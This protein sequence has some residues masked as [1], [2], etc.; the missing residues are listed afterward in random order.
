M[1][2]IGDR[3]RSRARRSKTALLVA[4]TLLALAVT[5][6]PQR[7]ARAQG[8]SLVRAGTTDSNSSEMTDSSRS[9][10]VSRSAN[11]A[12]QPLFQVGLEDGGVAGDSVTDCACFP[13]CVCDA[14]CETTLIGCTCVAASLSTCRTDCGAIDSC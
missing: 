5:P 2:S 7:D 13:I 4:G 8:G 6:I 9:P 11:A 1:T 12:G 14:S 10:E 3:A